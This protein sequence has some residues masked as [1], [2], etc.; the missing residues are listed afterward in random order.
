MSTGGRIWSI[1]NGKKIIWNIMRRH[2]GDTFF[3]MLRDE[4]CQH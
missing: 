3:V 1:S 4:A 2:V